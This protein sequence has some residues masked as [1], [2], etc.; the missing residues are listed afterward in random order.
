MAPTL[1]W[2]GAKTLAYLPE[3]DLLDHLGVPGHLDL[4]D[5][6]GLLEDLEQLAME[7]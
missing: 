5:L 7:Q 2:N 1:F 4:L 3:V 6:L